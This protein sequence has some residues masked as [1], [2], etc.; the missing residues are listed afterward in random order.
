KHEE[1]QQEGGIVSKNFTKKIQQNRY[2]SRR[3]WTSE[4]IPQRK[5]ILPSFSHFF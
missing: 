2:W 4:E 5:P 3:L 1:K